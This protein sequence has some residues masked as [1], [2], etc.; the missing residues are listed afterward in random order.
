MRNVLFYIIVNSIFLQANSQD[1]WQ[2][3]TGLHLSLNSDAY[4]VGPSF[5]AGLQ[6][7]LDKKKKWSFTPKVHYFQRKIKTQIDAETYE[8]ASFLSYSF[9]SNFNY[10]TGKKLN[11]GFFAGA[12]IGFQFA[13]DECYTYINGEIDKSPGSH[14][15]EFEYRRLMLTINFGYS[16]VLKKNHSI[17]FLVSGI[18]PYTETDMYGSYIEVL[19]VLNGGMRFIF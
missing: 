10:F 14:Y 15:Y 13:A 6:H 5:S 8:N 18:G 3:F 16:I 12:G 4:Y 11:K 1:K 2:P 7:F 17:Q 19:S 9:R